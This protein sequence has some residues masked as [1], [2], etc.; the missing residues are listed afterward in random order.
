MT[1]L[2]P[3]TLS[4]VAAALEA[5]VA[6]SADPNAGMPTV[7]DPDG[8]LE[9]VPRADVWREAVALVRGLGVPVATIP[10]HP[11][12]LWDFRVTL[13]ALVTPEPDG[14]Y[15]ASVPALPGISTGG[16]DWHDSDDMR[17]NLREA[18][19]GFLS[20]RRDEALGVKLERQA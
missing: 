9:R 5:K 3:H 8:D 13:E 11:P 20:V 15:S 14:G 2:D 16:K 7:L 6:A 1:P 18:T 17:K 19:E 12:F 10:P 4:V